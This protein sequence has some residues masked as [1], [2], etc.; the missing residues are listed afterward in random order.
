MEFSRKLFFLYSQNLIAIVLLWLCELMCIIQQAIFCL[1][2]KHKDQVNI[3]WV[4]PV[5]MGH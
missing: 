1:L 5:W 4:H 2:K 3:A